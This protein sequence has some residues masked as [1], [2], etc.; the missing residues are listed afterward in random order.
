MSNR[1]KVLPAGSRYGSVSRSLTPVTGTFFPRFVSLSCVVLLTFTEPPWGGLS[2]AR[3]PCPCCWRGLCQ[4][5]AG[6][7]GIIA[8][9][10]VIW[11]SEC[12][13]T[14]RHT[15]PHQ[16]E[17][18]RTSSEYHHERQHRQPAQDADHHAQTVRRYQYGHPTRKRRCETY[19][20]A[21]HHAG[22]TAKRPETGTAKKAREEASQ[23]KTPLP[24]TQAEENATV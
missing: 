1:K 3:H 2:T 11:L 22:G 8:P 6:G 7:G 13:Y 14:S 18:L 15:T 24:A 12:C 19:R 4:S 9:P 20:Q 16:R 5:G 21:H 23:G 17:T 10:L